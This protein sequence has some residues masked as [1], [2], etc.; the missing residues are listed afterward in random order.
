MKNYLIIINTL[1]GS[2]ESEQ[3]YLD[4]LLPKLQIMDINFNIQR[5]DIN[6]G[7][8][9]L[10]GINA[11]LIIGGDGTIV[12]II[13]FLYNNNYKIPI[14]HIPA[15]SG[16]GLC[17]SILF[18]LGEEYNLNNAVSLLGNSETKEIDLFDVKFKESNKVI[19]C[20]LSISWGIISDIDIETE[21]LRLLGSNRFTIGGVLS[22]IK[23]RSYHGT[24]RYL[25]ED[26]VTWKTI[27]GNFVY[28]LASNTTHISHNTY[29]NP[30]AKTNDGFIHITY[31]DDS[32][33]RYDLIW[34]LLGLEDGS[35][36]R[37]LNY[38]KTTS[39]ELI[40]YEGKLVVDGELKDLEEI[41]VKISEKKLSILV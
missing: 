1:S 30:G 5:N 3:I 37:Y 21:W 20:F 19:P 18:E 38:I 15:G 22:F 28:F 24:L 7:I 34:L 33:S 40:P 14:C 4:Y 10:I 23:K 17:K 12:P 2:G 25:N 13:K 9:D 39:F 31:I 32:I 29:S 16:N 36:M 35:H 27:K 26:K 11:I 41:N 8:I 6:I